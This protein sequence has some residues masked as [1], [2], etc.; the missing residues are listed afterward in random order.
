MIVSRRKSRLLSTALLTALTVFSAIPELGAAPALADE[1]SYSYFDLSYLHIDGA[2][3]GAGSGSIEFNE[4]VRLFGGGGF[5]NDSGVDVTSYTAGIGYIARFNDDVNLIVDL[6]YAGAKADFFFGE[7]KTD[8][9][10]VGASLRLRASPELEFEPSVG[11]LLGDTD[12]LA[13]GVDARFWATSNVAIQ[14]GIA[15]TSG[16]G[17]AAFTAGIRFGPKHR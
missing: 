7:L 3:G 11:Y 16:G 12:E 9:V 1:F 14:L 8:D 4:N 5:A 2:N 13:Y 17:D 6:G 10:L 15:G